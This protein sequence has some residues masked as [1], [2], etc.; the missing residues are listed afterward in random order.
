MKPGLAW[1]G[2]A[3]ALGLLA[4]AGLALPPESLAWRADA[5]WAVWRWFSAAGVHRTPLHLG[6]NL[7]G[8]ALLAALGRAARLPGAAALAWLVAWPLTHAPLMYVAP[9]HSYG[10]LSGVLHA[11]AAIAGLYMLCRPATARHRWVGLAL[12]AGVAL[13]LLLETPWQTP[14]RTD[15]GWGFPV[16]VV[17]HATGALAG[18][19]AG[20]VA[21]GVRRAGLS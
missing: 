13:K 14:L 12:L 16:A 10:G 5:P 3:A 20:A 9:L 7:A 8:L 11:G 1:T 19:L 21:L 15:A 2:L 4:L 6:A 18:W 17:A